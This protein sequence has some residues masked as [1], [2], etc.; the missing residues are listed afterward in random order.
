MIKEL[1]TKV[2]FDQMVEEATTVP[3]WERVKPENAK[4]RALHLEK[5][6]VI[7]ASGTISINGTVHQCVWNYQGICLDK[8]TLIVIEE[9]CL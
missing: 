5:G 8:R 1:N 2:P 3:V 4:F 7:S 6:K 9:G